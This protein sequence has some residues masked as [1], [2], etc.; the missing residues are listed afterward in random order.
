MA[1]ASEQAFTTAERLSSL[2]HAPSGKG[3][4]VYPSSQLASNLKLVSALLK[5][6][7]P[8]RVFY[9]VQGGYDTHATQL[10]THSGLLRDFSEAVNAFLKDM[11]AS[12]LSDRVLVLAFSEFGRRAAE[13]GELHAM[14]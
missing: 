11:D 7:T 1:R 13:K 14:A 8:A 9:A 4:A 6:D 10:G 3:D 2:A 5:S 12:G